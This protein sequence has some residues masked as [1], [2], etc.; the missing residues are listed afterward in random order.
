M[1]GLNDSIVDW[2]QQAVDDI[3]IIKII[4]L[5]RRGC[6]AVCSMAPYTAPGITLL[7]TDTDCSNGNGLQRSVSVDKPQR[8]PSNVSVTTTPR[9]TEEIQSLI[10]NRSADILFLVTYLDEE[11]DI[12][13]FFQYLSGVKN[14]NALTFLVV[15]MPSSQ[16][17]P[18][19]F[20]KAK[21]TIQQ[22]AEHADGI[23]AL[24]SDKIAEY[25]KI[26]KH[27][28][29]Y[30][31]KLIRI[32]ISG[33]HEMVSKIGHIGIDYADLKMVFKNKGFVKASVAQLISTASDKKAINN[34]TNTEFTINLEE[35]NYQALSINIISGETNGKQANDNYILFSDYINKTSPKESDIIIGYRTDIN[36]INKTQAV[37]LSTGYELN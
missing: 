26:D 11:Y 35:K 4:G 10:Y 2:K 18:E 22:I 36:F 30:I 8:L 29:T 28:S 17:E 32:C 1:E 15:N 34:I 7:V 5:G 16:K 14:E 19:N 25:Y 24:D 3:P 23:I 13:T 9:N 20:N 6:E 21:K 37:I 31:N 27:T 33:I 12:N